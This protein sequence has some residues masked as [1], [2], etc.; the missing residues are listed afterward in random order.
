MFLGSFFELPFLLDVG[1]NYLKRI[2]QAPD[3]DPIGYAACF[4][5]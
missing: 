3:D 5:F 4:V 2:I 1:D